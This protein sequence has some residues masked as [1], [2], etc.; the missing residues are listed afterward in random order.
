MNTVGRGTHIALED[1]EEP[2]V[3]LAEAGNERAAHGLLLGRELAVEEGFGLGVGDDRGVVRVLRGAKNKIGV[4]FSKVGAYE[5]A[6][7]AYL[8]L[9]AGVVLYTRA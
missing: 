4:E 2:D 8:D 5:D 1:V 9:V 3:R 6:G 7:A